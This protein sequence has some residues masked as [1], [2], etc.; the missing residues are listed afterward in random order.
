[1][2][3][4]CAPKVPPVGARRAAL[5]GFRFPRAGDV[6]AAADIAAGA[7]GLEHAAGRRSGWSGA[8][9]QRRAEADARQR[10]G[11]ASLGYIALAKRIRHAIARFNEAVALKPALAA[12]LVGRGLALAKSSGR[13]MRSRVSRRRRPPIRRSIWALASRHCGFVPWRCRGEGA[14][15]GAGG[16]L[17]E[18]RQEYSRRWWPRPTAACCF[19]SWQPSSVA[20]VGR[21]G[22][23]A[24][25]AG[26]DGRSG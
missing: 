5:P 13:L 12:A 17:D 16:K 24:S 19:A 25:R 21:A 11:P 6:C 26:G 20:M 4:G 2:A 7:A 8:R 9:V 10:I 3:A 23:R 14:D 18:A 1:M 15:G 22:P